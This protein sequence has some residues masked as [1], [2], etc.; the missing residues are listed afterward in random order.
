MPATRTQARDEIFAVVK[1]AVESIS[2]GIRPEV[3]W[4]DVIADRPTPDVST[5]GTK[6]WLKVDLFHTD[7]EQAHIGSR[8]QSRRGELAMNLF[9][10]VNDGLVNADSI[11]RTLEGAF[12]KRQTANGVWFRAPRSVELGTTGVYYQCSVTVDF[13]YLEVL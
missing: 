13:T 3:I 11:V 1:T 2:S 5:P 9:T 8:V 4:Q 6:N 12:V 10:P 7:S